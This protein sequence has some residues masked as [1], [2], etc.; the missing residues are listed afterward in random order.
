M[1]PII[2]IFRSLTWR[3]VHKDKKLFKLQTELGYFFRSPSLLRISLTH[4][5]K[6]PRVA[7]N[8]EQLEFL[9]DAILDHVIAEM[10]FRE[11]PSARE[12]LLTQRRSTLVQ[13]KYLGKIG[14]ELGLLQYIK[15][16]PSLNLSQP[17]VSERQLANVFEALIAA[18]KLDGGL[19]PCFQLI[20]RTVWRNRREAWKTLNY[21]G[22]LIEH[23]QANS[24]ENPRFIIADTE[25]AEHEKLFKV[26]VRI[27]SEIHATASEVTK[28]AAEQAASQKTLEIIK[29]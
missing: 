29:E 15:A 7:R 18:M 11:F 27:G 25:G 3:L 20:E 24:L 2:Y 4:K 22:L 26:A 1:N 8:Y 16:G 21:K 6:E 23:C 10:L 17:K 19:K 28:K 14:E 12:G 5:S 13:K 9:G